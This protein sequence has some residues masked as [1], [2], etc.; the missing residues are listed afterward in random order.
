MKLDD[1]GWF[2]PTDFQIVLKGLERASPKESGTVLVGGQAI[3]AWVHHYDIPIPETEM[4][5]ITQDVDFL[6]TAQ[7]AK[8][9]ATAIGAKVESAQMDDHTPN[10][11]IVSFRSPESGKTLLIDFL[12]L[13]KGVDENEVRSLAVPLEFETQ[14]P[15][16]VLHPILCLQSRFENLY[17]L[18]AKRNGNGI[19]Q[20]AIAI[21]IV[22]EYLNELIEAN[23][24]RAALNVVKRLRKLALSSAGMFVYINYGLDVLSA[25]DVTRFKHN[26]FQQLGWPYL[27]SE[28]SA[29]RAKKARVM[30]V[31][32]KMKTLKSEDT[33]RL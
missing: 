22:R 29:R 5:A 33:W 3:V 6:G 32:Q 25:I 31:R 30:A 13:L 9:L 2:S 23:E 8:L 16:N 12:G 7:E 18:S 17:G 1:Y 26:K 21:N 27:V 14:S 4:P 11:A 10:T 19:T 28:V 24:H 20:A 15:V